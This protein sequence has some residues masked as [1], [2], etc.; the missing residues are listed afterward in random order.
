MTSPAKSIHRADYE[1]A[2]AALGVMPKTYPDGWDTGR[3]SHD[4]GQLVYAPVG[5]M[6]LAT[7]DGLWLIPPQH[8]L[9]IPPHTQHAMRARGTVSM[10]SLYVRAD[11]IPAGF[12]RKPQT[13][14][15][16]P[17]LRELIGRASTIAI[18][19]DEDGHEGRVLS[20]I[21]GEIDWARD[22]VELGLMSARDARLSRVCKA[23]L[24]RPGDARSLVEWAREVHVSERTLARLF[25]QEFGV[26]FIG[27]RQ[28]VRVLAALPR[29]ASG[30][31]ITA[32][33]L[34]LGYETPGAFTHVF[35]RFM[36]VPPSKY[37]RQR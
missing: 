15:V 35:R 27:W 25:R 19:H 5:L 23:L 1:N 30:E 28:Q 3:H 36:G 2:P 31:G 14:R 9:W 4:R 33:A 22:A 12:P 34:E 21:L 17:F 10:Q 26:T 6:E 13:L 29:L 8:A 20:L 7:A 32:I 18:A 11:A 16:S 37:L 24:E